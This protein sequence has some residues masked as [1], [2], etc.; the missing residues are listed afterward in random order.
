[1]AALLRAGKVVLK[2]FGDNQRYDLVVD[3]DGK[4][5]R[6]QC[7]TGRVQKGSIV[8]STCSTNWSTKVRRD[9]RGQIDL[10][11]VYSPELDKTYLVPVDVVGLREGFLRL[12]AAKNG[13]VKGIRLAADFELKLA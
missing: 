1:M 10:F 12:E 11:A 5:I 7:K 8:F 13:Q 3:E 6:I 2:P 4:F 9:Y